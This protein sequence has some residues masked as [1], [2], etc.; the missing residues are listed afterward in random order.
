MDDHEVLRI[1]TGDWFA[2]GAAGGNIGYAD[3]LKA[4]GF[5]NA[6]LKKFGISPKDSAPHSLSS[7]NW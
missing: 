2:I 3:F 5:T 7:H 4:N 1:L 6:D